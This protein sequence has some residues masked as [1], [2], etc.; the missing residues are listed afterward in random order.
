MIQRIPIE[1]IV[2]NKFNP[3]SLSQD[4]YQLLKRDIAE[5]GLEYPIEVRPLTNGFCEIIDGEH[6]WKA[7][8]EL[9]FK[10]VKCEVKDIDE[11]EAKQRNYRLNSTRGTI[12]PLKEAQ[13]FQG[14]IESG[15]TQQQVAEKYGRSQQFISS[16]LALLRLPEKV[17]KKITTRV[18]T[19]SHGE[20]LARLPDEEAAENL[21]QRIVRK[22]LSIPATEK[23]VKWYAELERLKEKYPDKEDSITDHRNMVEAKDSEF[24]SIRDLE[25]LEWRLNPPPV[26]GK[27]GDEKDTYDFNYW[28]TLWKRN[29]EMYRDNPPPKETLLKFLSGEESYSEH[30]SYYDEV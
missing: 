24:P 7:C 23:W 21:A 8:K 26:K 22:K 20:L 13:L 19:P 17:K 10:E 1:K 18:V 28:S 29:V 16:R 12:D 25:D 15:M 27:P 9:G 11:A 2:P 6:R 14:E 5:H 30:E 3:N 4:Q